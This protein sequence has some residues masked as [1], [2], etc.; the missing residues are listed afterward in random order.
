MKKFVLVPDS[1]KGTLTSKEVCDILSEQLRLKYKDVDIVRI[2]IADGGEGSVDAFLEA[3]GGKKE[4]ITVTS[5]NFETVEAYYGLID[6]GKT[7]IIESSV[8]CGLLLVKKPNPLVTTTFGVGELIKDA[9]DKNVNKIII[10]LGGSGTNDGGAG[11]LAALGVKFYNDNNKTF[12]PVGGILKDI[13][14]IDITGIDQ[15]LKDIEIIIMCDVD[16]PLYGPEGAAYVFSPQKGANRK[17]V[18]ILD[19]NLKMYAKIMEKELGFTE[20]NFKGAGAA[21]GLAYGLKACL[22]AKIQMGIDT[23]LDVVGFDN[24]IKDADI[25]FTGEGKLDGQSLRGKVIS[26]VAHRAKKMFRKVIAV[27]GSLDKSGLDILHQG[28]SEILIT[29]YQNLPFEQAA[30]RAKEDMRIVVKKYLDN[31]I[32]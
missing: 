9:L 25:I 23:L 32:K 16:N 20:W 15:R 10:G 7:A 1:F 30:P 5:P 3:V 8:A 19:N 29:N 27:V 14:K 11:C 26:G 13:R 28:V 17:M 4:I 2:L 22:N 6:N 24:I 31:I 21:G 18:E 12:I